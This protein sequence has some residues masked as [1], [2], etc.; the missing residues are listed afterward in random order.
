M[1][2]GQARSGNFQLTVGRELV[3]LINRHVDLVRVHILYY[4]VH[5]VVPL[6]VRTGGPLLVAVEGALHE[7][8]GGS[9]VVG[10]TQLQP[11]YLGGGGG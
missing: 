3:L 9:L 5:G 10:Q 7:D 8:G 6:G 11:F 4:E 1:K 2:I